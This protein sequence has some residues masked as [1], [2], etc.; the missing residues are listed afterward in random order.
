MDVPEEGNGSS[1]GDPRSFKAKTAI[2]L[3]ANSA[4]TDIYDAYT[5]VDGHI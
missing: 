4:Y 1:S 2:K 3:G 5:G